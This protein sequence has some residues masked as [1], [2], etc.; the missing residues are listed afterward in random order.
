MKLK[1]FNKIPS[2]SDTKG[3]IMKKNNHYIEEIV[4]IHQ[5]KKYFKKLVDFA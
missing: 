5:N 3:L 1:I 4:T 2:H